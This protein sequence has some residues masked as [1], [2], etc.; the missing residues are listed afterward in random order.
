VPRQM[1]DLEAAA[2]RMMHKAF[3]CEEIV[4]PHYDCHHF[5]RFTNTRVAVSLI[6]CPDSVSKTG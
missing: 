3:L 2:I 1:H 4:S 5:F 6:E